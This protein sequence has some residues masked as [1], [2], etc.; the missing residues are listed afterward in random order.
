MR[1]LH[2]ETGNLSD[3][4]VVSIIQSRAI[5]GKRLKAGHVITSEQAWEHLI[6]KYTPQLEKR[7]AINLFGWNTYA[8]EAASEIWGKVFEKIDSMH[9]GVQPGSGDRSKAKGSFK[10]WLFTMF[11]RHCVDILRKHNPA[12]YTSMPLGK[13]YD[14]EDSPDRTQQMV[15]RVYTAESAEQEFMN[16][17]DR[18][19]TSYQRLVHRYLP[20]SKA[21][22]FLEYQ[23]G[24]MEKI[25]KNKTK[26]FRIKNELVLNLINAWNNIG[27]TLDTIMSESQVYMITQRFVAKRREADICRESG[28]GRSELHTE[29]AIA[30]SALI[31]GLQD[32]ASD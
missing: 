18:S 26:A 1:R 32:E 16:T 15:D 31:Q 14:D 28:I 22:F 19:D 20:R 4:E 25:S 30:I 10:G 29:L 5:R 2:L 27:H 13:I 11:D 8:G 23:I 21:V 7:A 6:E 9:C 12:K 3:E 17:R 24:L